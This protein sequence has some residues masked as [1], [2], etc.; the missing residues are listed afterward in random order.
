MN[1]HLYH[2]DVSQISKI[3]TP[4]LNCFYQLETMRINLLIEKVTCFAHRFITCLLG[5]GIQRYSWEVSVL[6]SSLNQEEMSLNHS[7]TISMFSNSFNDLIFIKP[8]AIAMQTFLHFWITFVPGSKC[9][10]SLVSKRKPRNHIDYCHSW[11]SPI[12][13]MLEAWPDNHLVSGTAQIGCR[14]SIY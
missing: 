14:L 1:D 4:G 3:L 12:C 7:L 2:C 6:K 9:L 11:L 13:Q 5:L 8:V 10:G